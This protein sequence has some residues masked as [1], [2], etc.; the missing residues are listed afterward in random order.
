M[1]CAIAAAVGVLSAATAVDRPPAPRV[2]RP[3]M[4]RASGFFDTVKL[5]LTGNR[6]TVAA[7]ARALQM[8]NGRGGTVCPLRCPLPDGRC[9][10]T[11]DAPPAIHDK[12][13]RINGLSATAA[14]ARPLRE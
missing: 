4:N 14:L 3:A 6:A 13:Q 10:R 7:R 9:P 1:D 12:C 5:L 2:S 8:T 11:V